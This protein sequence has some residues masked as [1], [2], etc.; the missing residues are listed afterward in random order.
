MTLHT[1][2]KVQK[3]V[4]TL[5]TLTSIYKPSFSWFPG[6]IE[7]FLRQLQIQCMVLPEGGG[8]VVVCT[9]PLCLPVT[10]TIPINQNRFNLCNCLVS[11]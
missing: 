4:I 7:Q 3:V 2:L 11:F 9:L 5:I 8:V 1:N 6:V 10:E